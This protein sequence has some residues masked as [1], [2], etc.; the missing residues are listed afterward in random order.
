VCKG[1]SAS[2]DGKRSTIRM[3][4]ARGSFRF[5]IGTTEFPWLVDMT[6]HQAINL[7]RVYPITHITLDEPPEGSGKGED[8]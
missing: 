4:R 2:K 6:I 7:H 1:D 3:T 5:G 8:K